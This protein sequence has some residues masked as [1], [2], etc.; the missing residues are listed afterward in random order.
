MANK[1]KSLTKKEWLAV[2][3]FKNAI[4]RRYPRRIKKIILFG[5]KAR[6]DSSQA[7]DIDLLVV[8]TK[9]GKQI[10]REI[11]S[12]THEPIIRFKALLSPITVEGKFFKEW[13]PLLDHIRKE[14]I[15]I[16]I[17]KKV[18]KNM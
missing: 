14:G 1:T 2:E 13:S 6:G 16:W 12:L 11:A 4:F 3:E 5:S 10:R 9:N 15:T 7:S 18:K 8:V 17:N